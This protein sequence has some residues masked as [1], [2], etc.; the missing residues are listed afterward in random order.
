[1]IAG[2]ISGIMATIQ[3][4]YGDHQ[5]WADVRDSLMDRQKLVR[6]EQR[7][8]MDMHHVVTVERLVHFMAA[9]SGIIM[10]NVGDKETARTILGE[11]NGL[12]NVQPTNGNGV[13]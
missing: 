1:M 8:L 13:Q 9:L 5:T 4:G 10:R 7:R 3:S 6:G 12:M 11:I 2:A